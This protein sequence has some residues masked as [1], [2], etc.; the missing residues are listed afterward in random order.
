[1]DKPFSSSLDNLAGRPVVALDILHNKHNKLVSGLNDMEKGYNDNFKL[2]RGEL[3]K[4]Y[5]ILRN[6][7]ERIKGLETKFDTLN[8]EAMYYKELRERKTPEGIYSGGYKRRKTV[9]KRRKTVNKRRKTN[10]M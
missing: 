10:K 4:M 6:N 3:E 7:N 9:N 8:G 5:A 1:M 2:I